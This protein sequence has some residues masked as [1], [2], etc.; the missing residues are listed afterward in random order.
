MLNLYQLFG[1]ANF[2]SF[3]EIAAAYKQKHTELFSSDS[4]LANIPK[5]RELK[6]AFDLLSNDEKREEYD[7][8]LGEFLEELDE[9]FAEAV[10]D[11]SRGELQK[12]IDKLNWCISKNPGE[13][14]YYETIGL[15]QRLGNDY[16]GALRSFKQGLKTG[17][18]KAFFHRNL[19][20][21]Y[22]LKHD[23]DNSDTHYLEAAEAFKELLQV[24]PKNVDAMEQLADIYSRMNFFEESLDLYTQ[25]LKRFPYAAAYH[26]AAGGVMYELDMVEEAETHLLEAL[27]IAPGDSAA[28]LFLGLVYF[29]RRLL[30]LAVQTLRD[31]LKNS[32]D[33]PEVV[34]LVV[35]IET[36][37]GEIG[38][39]VEEI[40]FDPAPDA[41]VEGL[42]KWYN[43]ET[44]MGVLTCAE[45]PEV[46]LH[47]SAIK[48][49]AAIELKKGDAVRFGIVKD[50]AS[51]I[52]VQVE[53][54][55]ESEA[56]DAMPGK[57][58]KYDIEKKIGIIRAHDGREI[59]FAF[60][61]LTE[62]ALE[63]LKPDM[64]ILFESKSITGLSDNAVEQATRI[65]MRKKKIAVLQPES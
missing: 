24:D 26:R 43:P 39:T 8:K 29:K 60:S 59:F 57:I 58:E 55:G 9:K 61:A 51:P 11:L 37:R 14:D 42:V 20:D 22:R 25:L 54:I 44:G 13:P 5:L 16:D 17:Q 32:P 10:D 12:S 65:R 34:Q 41:Y 62:E 7:E 36:I 23:E 53:K 47:Y 38:R 27:R 50:A 56:S 63:N 6:D 4:P 2:S 15:A 1:V 35:Q 3:E 52:A 21:I 40:V 45:Y 31:S 64:E 28:L 48:N 46:L 18:R 19:G 30:G 49:E 33:Q